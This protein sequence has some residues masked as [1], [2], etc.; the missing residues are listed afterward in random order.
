MG[1][2]LVKLW[3][4]RSVFFFGF[5]IGVVGSFVS[6]FLLQKEV[7]NTRQA[8]LVDSLKS[9]DKVGAILSMT[10][11]FLLMYGASTFELGIPLKFCFLQG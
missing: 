4:Y 1:G 8:K 3:G 11:L 10:G 5:A 7:K 2:V 9:L 6:L